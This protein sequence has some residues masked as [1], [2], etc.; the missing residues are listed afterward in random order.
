MEVERQRV[1]LVEHL[2]NESKGLVS[3]TLLEGIRSGVAFHSSELHLSERIAVEEAFKR[4]IL[5]V[6]CSTSTLAAGVNLPA[7]RVIIRSPWNGRAF[8]TGA[9][10]IQMI[11]RAGR[12]G[13]SA[14]S[15]DGQKLNVTPDSFII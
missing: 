10:Y 6:L 12:T 14:R 4:N 11:G 2:E 7:T 15:E 9:N 5:S 8:I 3:R 1:F 13:V